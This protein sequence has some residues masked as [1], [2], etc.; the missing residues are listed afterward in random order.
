MELE[1]HKP[2]SEPFTYEEALHTYF[3][4]ETFAP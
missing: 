1:V 4:F 2:G 3:G